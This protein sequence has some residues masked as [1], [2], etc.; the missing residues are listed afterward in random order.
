MLS[1]AGLANAGLFTDLT[2][3][4]QMN[5]AGRVTFTYTLDVSGLS[6]NDAQGSVFNER[7]NFLLA[8]GALITGIG[9]DVRLTTIGASWASEAVL[10]FEDQIDLAVGSL[11]SFPVSDTHYSSGGVVD[12]TDAGLS[13]IRLMDS[14]LDIEAYDS[15]VDNGGSGDAYFEAGSL[16]Y[17]GIEF[18]APGAMGLLGL[19]GLVLARRRRPDPIQM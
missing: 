8:P 17:I 12:L 13:N 7:I 10:R 4:D 18:P 3:H 1:S 19:G 16:L 14:T 5:P 2:P 15:F 9:W 11:D 6:F